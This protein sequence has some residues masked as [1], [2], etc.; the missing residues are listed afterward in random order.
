MNPALVREQWD[1]VTKNV[2]NFY[3]SKKT[4]T[5]LSSW[6]NL[7]DFKDKRCIRI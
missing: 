7:L 5:F 6:V 1:A 2:T 3:V 4:R